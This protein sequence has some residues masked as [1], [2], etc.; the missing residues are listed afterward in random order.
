LSSDGYKDPADNDLIF[1]TVVK[2]D[3]AIREWLKGQVFQ[4]KFMLLVV[5]LMLLALLWKLS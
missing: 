3:F 2:N 4:I 1:D 5:F